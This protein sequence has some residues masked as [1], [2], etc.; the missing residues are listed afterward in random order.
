M[1][2]LV[3]VLFANNI[4]L[5]Y[6]ILFGVYVYLTYRFLTRIVLYRH[7]YQGMRLLKRERFKEALEPFERAYSFYSKHIWI[8]RFRSITV[9]SA[10][11][12]TLREAALHN[13]AYCYAQM[14]D[15]PQLKACYERIRAEFPN[16]VMA[17]T[18]L[19]FIR[20]V[21]KSQADSP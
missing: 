8:D 3:L 11:R 6:V 9:L 1:A 17:E 2:L 4:P 21:E 14:G 16:N 20:S 15:I 12:Y 5:G 10:S 18:G 13:I 19:K 7:F